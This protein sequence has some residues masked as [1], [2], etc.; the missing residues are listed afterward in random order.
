MLGRLLF[1]FLVGKRRR[2]FSDSMI[3]FVLKDRNEYNES[4]TQIPR[5]K[6]NRKL[7]LYQASHSPVPTFAVPLA[8]KRL[9]PRI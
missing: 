6:S 4:F 2:R 9:L 3:V 7:R 1:P 8:A 5:T